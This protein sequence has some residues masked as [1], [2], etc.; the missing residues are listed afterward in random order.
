MFYLFL[1]LILGC[2]GVVETGQENNVVESGE[3][4]SPNPPTEPCA[5]LLGL[6]PCDFM[7][8]DEN[9]DEVAFHSLIGKP[10]ILD[11]STMW[12]GP[13][14]VAASE[15]QEVQN[16][17]PGLSY[18][19][20]LIENSTGAAPTAA[21]LQLWKSLHEID[22]APVWGASR[23]IITSNPIETVG[24]FYLAGWPT[25]YFFDDELRIVGYQKG[26]D[27]GI[28]EGWAESLTQ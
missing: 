6:Q 23:D 4:A 20:I 2:V 12:C 13:C 25:F 1:V 24:E 14:N 19:T 8:I 15:V 21:D 11:L 10:V 17:Y 16:N 3:T 26:F 27:S 18:V 22:A 9:G 7:A 28:I 5:S